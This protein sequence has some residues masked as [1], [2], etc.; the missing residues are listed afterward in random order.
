MKNY[1][2]DA[3]ANFVDG[4]TT[5]RK[6]VDKQ[7]IEHELASRSTCVCIYES[8]RTEFRL[9]W[10]DL[11]TYEQKVADAMKPTGATFRFVEM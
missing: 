2:P 9:P 4:C 8:M 1:G 11:A 10:D 5:D 3:K 7:V 6:V